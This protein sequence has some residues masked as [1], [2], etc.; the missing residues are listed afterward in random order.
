MKKILF[1]KYSN[2]RNNKFAIRTDIIEE[3]GRYVEKH[4]MYSVGIEHLKKQARYYDMY[5]AAYREADLQLTPSRCEGD[6][7]VYQYIYG[8]TLSDKIDGMI[9]SGEVE[10][11]AS[12][13][14]IFCNTVKKMFGCGKWRITDDFIKTF[15]EVKA[16]NLSGCS[17]VNIDLVPDNVILSD[18]GSY[19]TDYEWIFDF[20]I[21][22]DY[23][24][25]RAVRTFIHSGAKRRK[26]NQEKI[27]EQLGIDTDYICIYEKMEKNFQSYVY[28]GKAATTDIYSSIGRKAYG[29]QELIAQYTADR[30]KETPTVYYNYGD[31]YSE[32]NKKVLE[33]TGC[34]YEVEVPEG[35]CSLRFD[36]CEYPCLLKNIKVSG[37]VI[38]ENTMGF[39]TNGIW[40]GDT[41][42][43]VT[44][45]AQII[46]EPQDFWCRKGMITIEA[47]VLPIGEDTNQRLNQTYQAQR[48]AMDSLFITN[49][50]TKNKN[51]KYNIEKN[52]LSNDGKLSLSGW[53]FVKD[54]KICKCVLKTDDKEHVFHYGIERR[55]VY[56]AYNKYETALNCGFEGKTEYNESINAMQLWF[57]DEY[58]IPVECIKVK[59]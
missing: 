51:V 52:D 14:L 28:D 4:A 25:F 31:G 18:N 55:D 15:G 59:R 58:N 27:F 21:P 56:E 29:I 41:L 33:R 1:S 38:D 47:D 24:V 16:D 32:Q 40:L 3:N 44:N 39:N 54:K 43:F 7:L 30:L 57:Y 23:V 45:D 22:A 5:N 8:N 9:D 2:E 13:L 11:A 53:L 35:V 17:F 49:H 6:F 46:V 50:R 37:G 48:Q 26:I 20:P 10:K 19:V 42:L 12:E 36:P 34:C